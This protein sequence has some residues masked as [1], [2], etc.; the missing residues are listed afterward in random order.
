MRIFIR[1]MRVL[2]EAVGHGV[3]KDQSPILFPCLKILKGLEEFIKL[4][5]QIWLS[6][7]T[8][9]RIILLHM[10]MNLQNN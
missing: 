10:I 7:I 6:T 5:L 9:E 3:I 1:E 8:N 2:N 4:G